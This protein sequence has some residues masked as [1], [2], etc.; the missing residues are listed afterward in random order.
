VPVVYGQLAST[1]SAPQPQLSAQ[2]LSAQAPAESDFGCGSMLEKSKQAI[3]AQNFPAAMDA[4]QSAQKLCV[5][6]LRALFY[7]ADAQM[8]SRQFAQAETTLRTLLASDSTNAQALVL[9]GQVQYLNNDDKDAEDTFRKAIAAAPL[10]P[11][12]HYNLGRMY[13]EDERFQEAAAQFQT[14][15]QMEGGFYRA[16]DNLGLCDEALGHDQLA[17]QHYLK[18]LALVYK[19]HPEYD[20]VY[21]DLAEYMLKKGDNQRAFNLAVE[22]ARRNPGNPRNFYLAG[23]ALD[24]AGH[25]QTSLHWLKRAAQMDPAFPEP[26]YLMARI[27]WRLGDG[28]EAKAEMSTFRTLSDKAPK[29]RR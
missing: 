25:E 28:T 21:E 29:V 10:N 13:Y 6:P 8:L 20:T 27:Y 17:L 4:A 16:Y 7:L 24:Q 15:I 19:D 5:D 22:A 1:V 26:H 14:V 23:K 3:E 18:A 11:E 9:L 2:G 12:P